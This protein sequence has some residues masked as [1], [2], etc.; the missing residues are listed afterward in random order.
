MARHRRLLPIASASGQPELSLAANWDKIEKAYG[1][2]LADDVR[3]RIRD[4]T[5]TFA[6]WEIFE[7]TA[8]PLQS[9]I[10]C[11]SSIKSAANSLQK[12]LSG[13][14]DGSVDASSYAESLIKR[15][16]S[17]SCLNVPELSYGPFNALSDVLTSLAVACI[18]ALRDM[19]SPDAPGHREGETWEKWIRSLTKIVSEH[20]LPH[21]VSKGSD[22]SE[23]ASP[24]TLLVESLQECVPADA[25]RHH[26]SNTALAKAITD[27]RRQNGT[28]ESKIGA[29]KVPPKSK[30]PV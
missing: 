8:R 28:N 11:V 6:L 22:K 30:K 19:E 2:P 12:A 1:R 20:G 29:K 13:M 23:Q 15:H 21:R 24:F 10:D 7:R 25:R 4:V 27:A 3:Q 5:T 17:C 26:H 9:A 18:L 14:F 16:F